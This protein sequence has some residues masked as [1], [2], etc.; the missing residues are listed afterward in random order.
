MGKSKIGKVTYLGLRPLAEVQSTK[1]ASVV[2]GK[3]LLSPEERA[4]RSKMA[5]EWLREK[6]SNA[7][8]GS[9]KVD[10]SGKD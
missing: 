2:F 4:R 5:E 8:N 3:N 9:A 10:D 1:L 6:T 7:D